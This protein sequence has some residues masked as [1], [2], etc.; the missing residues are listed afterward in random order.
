MDSRIKT[1][2]EK[3]VNYSCEV[4]PGE[5]VLIEEVGTAARPLIQQV[6]REVYKAGGV[7]F[8]GL[9]DSILT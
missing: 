8:L 3:I 5:N 2:A 4:Q 9:S 1:F 7:P 6:I